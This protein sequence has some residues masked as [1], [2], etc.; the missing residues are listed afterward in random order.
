MAGELRTPAGVQA[1][2]LPR[3]HVTTSGAPIAV[4]AAAPAGVLHW[5]RFPLD[6]PYRA[7]PLVRAGDTLRAVLPAQPAAGK[8]EY[9]L[10]LHGRDTLRVP[11]AETVVL[12]YRGE[13]PASA[14]VPHVLL[15]FLSMLVALRAGL[16]A[17]LGRDE[18]WLAWATLAGFTVGGMIFGPI[19]QKHAFGAYWTGVPFG[20]D[21]TDN[22]TLI[23]WL[24]WLA[25]VLVPTARPRA[26]RTLVVAAAVLTIV[27]YLIPHSVQGSQL[28]Y[29]AQA[30]SAV[31]ERG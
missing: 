8:V 6:E 10:E 15:M 22:K 27:V 31:A 12:R 17:A 2:S 26:R 11:A 16:G 9:F 13:V 24:A 30:D 21:L 3:S 14:L 28:D 29:E 23:M 20:W 5:R 7:V 4:P 25:A 19:V 18:P 1:Y